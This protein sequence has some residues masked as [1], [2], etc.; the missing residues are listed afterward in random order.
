M[1][2]FSY[3]DLRAPRV[4]QALDGLLTDDSRGRLEQERGALAVDDWTT[5]DRTLLVVTADWLW[6]LGGMAGAVLSAVE[7]D[8]VTAALGPASP[9]TKAQATAVEE[10]G[11]GAG[12]PPP[13]FL[14]RVRAALGGDEAALT[15]LVHTAT[16]LW[17]A[18][19]RRYP[20]DDVGVLL[21]L[22]LETL[23][24]GPATAFNDD[25]DRWR[26]SLRV[27]PDEASVRRDD[28]HVSAGE[29][30]AV[31][32]FW[33]AAR[34]PGAFD[35]SWLDSDPAGVAWAQLCRQVA[36]ERAA[37]LVTVLEPVVDGDD[38]VVEPPAGMP[39]APQPN[40][41]GGLPTQL[42]VWAM[43]T[44]QARFAVGRLPMDP[45]ATIAADALTLPLPDRA[46]SAR[47][48]WW[49]S[50]T[51]AVEVGL[52]GEWLLDLG[53]TPESLEALYVVG[54]GDEAPDEHLRAQVDA[55]ELGVLRLGAPTN[56]VHGA[57]A[58][59]LA[60]DADGWRSVA[61]ARLSG[62]RDDV[63]GRTLEQH[64]TGSSGVLPSFPGADVPDDTQDS[65]RM[66]QALWPP[67]LGHWLADV[68]EV[69]GDAFRVNQWA[70]PPVD[71][72]VPS[73][74]EI[75]DVLHRDPEDPTV[76]LTEARFCPEGPLMPMRIGDQPYGL[77]PTTALS[78]WQPDDPAVS[79]E[80]TRVEEGMARALAALRG[81]WAAAAR[82]G[83][84]VVGAGTERFMELLAREA[85]S[86][87]FVH[88]SFLPAAAWAMPYQLGPDALQ[89]FDDLAR[90]LYSRVSDLV[91][92]SPATTYLT[93]GHAR[94][95][96]LRLVRPTRT[97][98]REQNREIGGRVALT[99]FLSLLLDL[100]EPM[101]L[102]DVFSTWWV[103]D[104]GSEWQ[105]RS[106]PDSLLIRLLV[107]AMQIDGDW[108]RL[109]AG[110]EEALRALRGQVEATRAITHELDQPDWNPD[111]ARPRHRR[112][113]LRDH[114][115]G[116]ATGAARARPA[117]HHRQRRA[118][119]RPVGDRL[120]V[121]A[122]AG[123]QHQRPARAPARRLRLGRR[124]LPRRAGSDRRGTA[125]HPVV[126]PDAGGRHPARQVPVL[127]ARGGDQRRRSQPVG[128]EHQ[129]GQGAA[130]R[131]DRRRGSARLPR[132]R[133]RRAARR[134]RDRRPPAGEGVA[135]QPGV[136]HA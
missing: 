69:T 53:V 127:R 98:H 49:S 11:S 73:P 29:L 115:P 70:F 39:E 117:R 76:V 72:A 55:G 26:L 88:R 75:R 118:P 135:H 40:R 20:F 34:A 25:P 119:D 64:L 38:L 125:A 3:R 114:R 48:A 62:T 35:P 44:D 54:V 78:Q 12:E 51:T 4:A 71:D 8:P 108:L 99:R 6:Q 47:D 86:R 13:D 50:W 109:Q 27:V 36:P 10:V 81:E 57:P 43:T 19:E 89:E 58:A 15:E 94:L 133:D 45:D 131:G 67:L 16:S 120:R 1:P 104:R 92:T 7:A 116:R 9:L 37:W 130:G 5:D 83:G 21:P 52:G 124:A 30:A 101:D 24:D 96:R 14:D 105:L 97:L 100:D 106:L 33:A 22:R 56:T 17:L 122:A 110:G 95:N 63:V 113:T 132:L 42:T 121:A 82:R 129:L 93:N 112:A 65:K 60:L 61:R 87:R 31:R 90:K 84:T 128:D 85:S 80:Q 136:R 46:D 59:D 2:T 41:V 68:W 77:L 74:G 134:A 32:A 91:G 66:A 123:A 102:T 126:R 79:G 107:H 23:F 103:L 28:A 18:N 111:D